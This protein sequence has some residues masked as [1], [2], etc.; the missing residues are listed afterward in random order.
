MSS[1]AD[2][3][4]IDSPNAHGDPALIDDR[5]VGDEIVIAESDV[6]AVVQSVAAY[7]SLAAIPGE[8]WDGL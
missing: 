2:A 5:S 3:T 7:P 8:V 1:I 6:R 4:A